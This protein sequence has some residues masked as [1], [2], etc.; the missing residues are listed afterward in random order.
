VL[1]PTLVPGETSRPALDD[2]GYVQHDRAEMEVLFALPA[3]L[4]DY[5]RLLS[6]GTAGAKTP[7][8]APTGLERGGT[9]R[10]AADPQQRASPIWRPL[11]YSPPCSMKADITAQSA[12]CIGC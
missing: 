10:A 7:L 5:D 2:I 11:R 3:D 4:S 12:Q 6:A 1:R 8:T 9:L